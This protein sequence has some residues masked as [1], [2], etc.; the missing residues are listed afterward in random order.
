VTNDRNLAELVSVACHDIATPL[1]TVYGFARTL[2]RAELEAPAGRYVEMI[3][4]A[5]DQIGELL[6]RLRLV[7]RVEAGRYEPELETVDS[8]ALVEDAA[9]QLEEGR[10]SVAGEGSEVRVDVEPTRWALAQ[11]ARA[12]ARH[13]GHETV[14]YAVRGA[15]LELSPL[16]PTAEP[17][18]LGEKLLEFAGPAAGRLIQA[19]GG[20]LTADRG[21][22]L[23]RL[24]E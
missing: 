2:E 6:D 17:V 23:I 7:A 5:S 20:T 4:A 16:S 14:A 1:A 11:L 22:L 21:R 19:G 9:A 15:E 18:V 12:A 10:V 3:G 24:P 13:G 8:L